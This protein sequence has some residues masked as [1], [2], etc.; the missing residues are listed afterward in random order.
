MLI[1]HIY[2]SLESLLIWQKSEKLHLKWSNSFVSKISWLK[3]VIN[4]EVTN[5]CHFLQ[6]F[7]DSIEWLCKTAANNNQYF[8]SYYYLTF[9]NDDENQTMSSFYYR[10]EIFCKQKSTMDNLWILASGSANPIIINKLYERT[11]SSCQLIY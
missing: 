10:Y 8:C 6:I 7:T 1:N 2:R 11:F 4:D 5:F 3:R 9:Y